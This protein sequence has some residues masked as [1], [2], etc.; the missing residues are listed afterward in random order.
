[1]RLEDG[2]RTERLLQSR[3]GGGGTVDIGW[4]DGRSPPR[5]E[6]D[7]VPAAVRR[8]GGRRGTPYVL[9]PR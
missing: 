7:G 4:A 6:A 3:A 5:V 1:M 2:R 9:T 8:C